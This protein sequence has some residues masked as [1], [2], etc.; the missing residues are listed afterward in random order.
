MSQI[1]ITQEFKDLI[2]GYLKIDDQIKQVNTAMKK[3]K[4]EKN[5]YSEKILKYMKNNGIDEISLPDGGKLELRKSKVRA[6]LTKQAIFQ[7]L[8][9]FFNDDTK[10]E[11]LIEFIQDPK[12]RDIVEREVLSRKVPR[13]QK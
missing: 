6:V 9:T 5:V 7:N 4:S 1:Q 13:L 3:I 2:K 11:Q 8:K 10:A 12:N